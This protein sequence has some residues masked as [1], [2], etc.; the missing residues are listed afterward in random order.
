MIV[1]RVRVSARLLS[2]SRM[3]SPNSRGERYV[4]EAL[5]Y[6]SSLRKRLLRL[7][8]NKADAEELLYE[9][10]AKLF[11]LGVQGREIGNVHSYAL[12]IGRNMAI[13]RAR[14]RKV[15]SIEL[16]EDMTTLELADESP[17]V[18][19]RIT[20]QQQLDMVRLA[21]RELPDL[22]R[23]VFTLHRCFGRTHAEIAKQL[24]ISI[25][26]VRREL[27]RALDRLRALDPNMFTE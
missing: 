26:T 6:E 17:S 22:C 15:A 1:A 9:I 12:G 3:E 16:V 25:H 19:N 20:A 4:Q 7:T 10:Y 8:R 23:Q 5:K 24:G 14:R 21:L 11:E 27:K 18:E 13:D 2:D